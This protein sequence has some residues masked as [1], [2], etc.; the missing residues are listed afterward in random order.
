[1]EFKIN[2]F[3]VLNVLSYS[4]FHKILYKSHI[5][6]ILLVGNILL[7]GKWLKAGF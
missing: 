5:Y 1:M 6:D 4:W 7:V 2:Y 3:N